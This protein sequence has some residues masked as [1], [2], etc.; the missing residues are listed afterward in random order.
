MHAVVS[1]PCRRAS[2]PHAGTPISENS[3]LYGTSTPHAA[4]DLRQ[5]VCRTCVPTVTDGSGTVTTSQK[6]NNETSDAQGP[7]RLLVVRSSSD[8]VQGRNRIVGKA[9]FRFA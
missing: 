5:L 2:G 8:K 3:L 7:F 6:A 4:K 9:M 1:R